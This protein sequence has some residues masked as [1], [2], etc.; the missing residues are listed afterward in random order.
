M[1]MKV[2]YFTY[3]FFIFSTLILLSAFA[4]ADDPYGQEPIG[5]ETY[6]GYRERV[7]PPVKTI[8]SP[9][10]TSSGGASAI[11]TS[12]NNGING[13]IEIANPIFAAF[14]GE[15]PGGQYLFA[16]SLFLILIFIIVLMA[17]KEIDFFNR[18]IISIPLA[19]IVAILAT[20][21][22]GDAE[23]VAA[24]I[25]P[26]STLGITIAAG[27]PFLIAFFGINTLFKGPHA[28][29]RKF[30]WILFGVI[31]V[32][33]WIT[34]VPE[35]SAN[36]SFAVWIYPGFAILSLI[37]ISLDGTIQRWWNRARMETSLS[38]IGLKQYR[39]LEVEYEQTVERY[40]KDKDNY[41]SIYS[42]KLKGYRGYKHDIDAITKTMA[43]IK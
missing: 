36:N 12:I 18:A 30:A 15:V 34:R 10:S 9:I 8:P 29:L 5:G 39:T 32:G 2:N 17:V 14:V 33:L 20:R 22:I 40:A 26:Y 21:W 35:M 24:M 11:A 28:T 42:A 13:L 6:D 37:M 23:F 3:A 4:S 1:K 31:F 38:P 16:K 41:Q 25:L 19:I 7:A 43:A 27:I